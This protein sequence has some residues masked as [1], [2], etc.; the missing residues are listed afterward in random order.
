M[1]SIAI[2]RVLLCQILILSLVSYGFDFSCALSNVACDAQ[3][4]SICPG[5]VDLADVPPPLIQK[6]A[7]LTLAFET[8]ELVLELPTGLI[9]YVEADSVR[10]PDPFISSED[11]RGPP[12]LS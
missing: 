5:T 7:F 3:C 4:C 10:E 2:V 8:S 6:A 9:Q 1:K 12:S 11:V